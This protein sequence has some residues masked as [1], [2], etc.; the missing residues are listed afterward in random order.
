ME[1]IKSGGDTTSYERQEDIEDPDYL[2][3]I[4][5]RNILYFQM[6]HYYKDLVD[7]FQ[8]KPKKEKR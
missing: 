4:L 1:L 7:G 5:Y 3:D 6:N 8:E 2:Y